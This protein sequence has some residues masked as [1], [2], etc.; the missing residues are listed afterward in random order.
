MNAIISAV[1]CH[2]AM[3]KYPRLV[4]AVLAVTLLGFIPLTTQ[5]QS[6]PSKPVRM[7]VPWAPGGPVSTL[8]HV[9]R[10]GL[11]TRWTQPVIVDNRPG[12]NAVLGTEMA[13]RAT[14]DG[15]TLLMAAAGP[16]SILPA[17]VA[18]LP[19]DAVKDFQRIV[20]VATQCYVLFVHPSLPAHSIK[21]LLSL[22]QSKPREFTFSS[23]GNGSPSH[24]S[25]ELLKTATKIEMQHVPYKGS[26]PAMLDVLG[27]RITL[28]FGTI[29]PVLPQIQSG[30]L[31]ALAVTAPS[32]VPL[33]PTIPTIAESGYPGFEALGWEGIV[34]PA[35][36][37]P[38]I[39]KQL[40]EETMR[41]LATP[42]VKQ[43]L[44]AQGFE[45]KPSTTEDFERFYRHEIDKWSKVIKAAGIRAEP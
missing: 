3:S 2:R 37:A 13:A 16:N 31:R 1:P 41:I 4:P 33:L 38:A 17:L 32:R 5:A 19:Y 6:Y 26:V 11:S 14:P 34:A 25:G 23:A 20:L 8:A 21:D 12:A 15:Y 22:A 35:G 43:A 29:P 39:V 36:I 28:S 44:L 27:G 45:L 7:I 9:V 42:E 24:L 10:Q 40:H 18:K 30:K